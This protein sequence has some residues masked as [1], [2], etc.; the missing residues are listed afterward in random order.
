MIS[1]RLLL[2][3]LAPW[4]FGHSMG[5]VD[6]AASQPAPWSGASVGPALAGVIIVTFIHYC[7]IYL[8]AVWY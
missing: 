5:H 8:L 3:S 7:A 1:D 6:V 2:V 4:M